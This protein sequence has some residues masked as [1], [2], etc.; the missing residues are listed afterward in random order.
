[1]KTRTT[2]Y[3]DGTLLEIIETTFHDF[4][5]G[6]IVKVLN[7]DWHQY[8]VANVNSDGSMGDNWRTWWVK[9]NQL[10]TIK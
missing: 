6:T 7:S 5:L 3:A 10:I 8:H 1:M 9:E 4:P 2:D